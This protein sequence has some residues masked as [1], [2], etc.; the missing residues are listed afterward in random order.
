MKR[1]LVIL[2]K[3]PI[4]GAVNTRLCPPLTLNQAAELQRCF[5]LDALDKVALLQDVEVVLAYTPA[6]SLPVFKELASGIGRLMPQEG[7]DLGARMCRCFEGLCEPGTAVVLIGTDTPTLPLRV[8]TEAFCILEADG[9]DIVFGPS[10]DGGYYL[11]AMCEPHAEVFER[12]RWGKADVM[13][14][15]LRR[16]AADSLRVHSLPGWYDIDTPDDLL[17]LGRELDDGPAHLPSNTAQ[18]L[19]RKAGAWG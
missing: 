9:A 16:A 18:S 3:A 5:I 1:T 17:R 15:S 6:E 2:A 19:R 7:C 8:L 10:E 11:I 12:I 14:A 13:A 4:P